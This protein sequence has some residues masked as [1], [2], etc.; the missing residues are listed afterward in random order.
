MHGAASRHARRRA[1]LVAITS[2]T[3]GQSTKTTNKST[4]SS[5]K[6]SL[7]SST[8]T[9]KSGGSSTKVT[10]TKVD[11]T[12]AAD[13]AKWSVDDGTTI[14]ALGTPSVGEAAAARS[15]S[16]K[17][18]EASC[19]SSSS[20]LG[21]AIRWPLSPGVSKSP[22]LSSISKRISPKT[23][24]PYPEGVYLSKGSQS[25][26]SD[27]PPQGAAGGGGLERRRA[28]ITAAQG[29][30][31]SCSSHSIPIVQ[32]HTPTS[33]L[34]PTSPTAAVIVIP[35]DQS[36]TFST[37]PTNALFYGGKFAKPS[38]TSPPTDHVYSFRS[39]KAEVLLEEDEEDEE[40][41]NEIGFSTAVRSP[42]QFDLEVCQQNYDDVVISRGWKAGGSLEDI[43]QPGSEKKKTAL[44]ARH[45]LNGI[46]PK[47]SVVDMKGGV[48]V[49]KGRHPTLPL[50][51]THPG[52]AFS[53]SG[54]MHTRISIDIEEG[55]GGRP[56]IAPSS[57]HDTPPAAEPGIHDTT[58][59]V[60]TRRKK[61]QT[62]LEAYRSFMEDESLEE[63]DEGEGVSD[64]S[65]PA[66][67]GRI[68]SL[69]ASPTELTNKPL[70]EGGSFILKPALKRGSTWD[71]GLQDTEGSRR[72][73]RIN[74]PGSSQSVRKRQYPSLTVGPPMPTRGTMR[75]RRAVNLT[76][77]KT[78]VMV[79]SNAKMGIS[80]IM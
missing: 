76:D 79:Q 39:S 11:A 12:K 13:A 18:G 1:S 63:E 3:L 27:S 26:S 4:K 57:V 69:Q 42:V 20:S 9:T 55:V 45:S 21:H 2:T 7:K 34:S 38:V 5:S 44:G 10:T 61:F 48:H 22:S 29:L 64:T 70:G 16:P 19:H 15:S 72:L 67:P 28:S 24:S 31:P 66:S 25:S 37:H 73:V 32:C 80:D 46:E 35:T 50:D 49:Y 43:H 33:P 53:N 58:R 30:T 41:E 71:G 36:V 65:K 74:A 17:Q 77:Q 62:N 60:R 23:S 40:A 6:S 54:A 78:C 51:Y 56:D 59:R 75:R 8:K 47:M 52:T 68:I 14:A